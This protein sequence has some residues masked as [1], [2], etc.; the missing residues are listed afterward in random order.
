MVSTQILLVAASILASFSAAVPTDT[1]NAIAVPD[2]VTSAIVIDKRG[3]SDTFDEHLQRLDGISGS[4]ENTRE[5]IRGLITKIREH[6]ERAGAAI[7]TT[8]IQSLDSQIDNGI[9]TIGNFLAPI[10]GGLSRVVANAILGPFVQSVT[11]GAEVVL[12]NLVG[13]AFDLAAAPIRSMTQNVGRLIQQARSQNMDVSRLQ[14]AHTRLQKALANANTHGKRD[15]DIN[16][17]VQRL[18]GITGSIDNSRQQMQGLINRL[19]EHPDRAGAEV[20][21][22]TLQGLDSQIDNGIATIANALSPLTGGISKAVGD[23]ILGS[24]AQSVTDGVEVVLG[25]VVGG[26]FDLVAAPIRSIVQNVGRLIQLGQSQNVDVSR[27]QQAHTR[28]EKALA[29]ASN[30]GKRDNLQTFDQHVQRLDGL[31]GSLENSREQIRGLITKIREHPERAGAAIATTAIQS[32]D[33]QIDN[34]IA[35]IGN[36]L[37]P[38]TGGLSRVVA[39]AILGPFVQSVTDGAEVV[40]GNLVGGAF[41]LAAAPV[42]AMTQNIGR[43]IQQARANNMDVS[44]LERAHSNLQ[45]AIA[46]HH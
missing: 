26:A 14:Q 18:D 46:R 9:A 21:T 43:L 19:R 34:G 29:N 28:L 30:K 8:A 4:L 42:R 12:G 7:A 3:G 5:Q 2:D 33:S 20:V 38:V 40:L 23:A 11:D 44:R 13:G 6:P 35:T 41:D 27:L 39:N 45:Q 32:L 17:E 25:N 37:A 15:F 10:T 36:F 22:A 24:F 16:A 31:A 1:I